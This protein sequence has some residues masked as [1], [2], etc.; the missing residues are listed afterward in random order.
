MDGWQQP[1]AKAMAGL[2]SMRGVI[3]T[4][5]VGEKFRS[6]VGSHAEL[7]V[8][9]S[10][11]EA[12]AAA[13]TA[14]LFV[15]DGTTY[16]AA[17]ARAL[18]A[19]KGQLRWV[20]L[21]SMGYDGL[22]QHGVPAGIVVTNVGG[23]YAPAVAEHAI[24]LLLTLSRRLIDSAANTAKRAHDRTQARSIRLLKDSTIVLIGCGRSRR[25]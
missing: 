1:W 11:D 14:D 7:V 25:V 4:P 9:R 8:A 24:A 16:D 19:D 12:V 23:L 17:L 13:R 5:V 10:R 6:A 15:I 20:Q 3:F 18:A 22:T 21:V 2:E